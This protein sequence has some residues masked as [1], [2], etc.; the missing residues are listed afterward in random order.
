MAVAQ[1]LSHG[2]KKCLVIAMR[3]TTWRKALH[4]VL[5]FLSESLSLFLTKNNQNMDPDFQLKVHFN[6]NGVQRGQ[7][8]F[9]NQSVLTKA[10]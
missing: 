1:F 3:S 8:L 4:H 10:K 6:A 2:F 7:K 9:L 5:P